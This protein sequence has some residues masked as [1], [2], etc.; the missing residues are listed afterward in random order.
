MFPRFVISYLHL[1]LVFFSKKYDFIFCPI[2]GKSGS[3][4]RNRVVPS[5]LPGHLRR[6]RISDCEEDPAAQRNEQKH[7]EEDRAC[8]EDGRGR[9]IFMTTRMSHC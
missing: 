9:F 3:F 1:F 4:R 6:E 8:R 7:R 5:L 2:S